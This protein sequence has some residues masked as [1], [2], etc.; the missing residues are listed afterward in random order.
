MKEFSAGLLEPFGLRAKRVSRAYGAF[1]CDT[2]QG[3]VLV[4]ATEEPEE[5]LR[6]AHGAKEHLARR[7]FR[8]TDRYLLN[9]EGQ[10]WAEQ[11]GER[12]TVR[13]WL[14]AEEADLSQGDCGVRMAAL[15][16]RMHRAAAGYEAPEQS[17][18]VNRCFEWPQRVYKESRKLQGYGRMLRKNGRYTEFDLMVLAGLPEAQ[19]QAEEAQRFFMGDGLARLAER[20]DREKAVGHGAY[21]DHTVLLGRSQSMITDLEGCCYM[22][23]VVDLAVLLERAM[24]KN[25]WEAALGFAMLEGYDR[26]CPLGTEERQMVYAM[27]LYPTRFCQLCGEA[28]HLKRSWM[29]IAYKRKLEELQRLQEKRKEFLKQLEHVLR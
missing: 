2:N 9:Q 12:Y 29:P 13:C 18:V 3:T 21:S 14:R 27:L 11:G 8:G 28:Y 16:G 24:R 1:I 22:I 10:I 5:V 26:W 20:T 25:D 23:P 19:E 4:K 15:L 6:F 7:G 17:R